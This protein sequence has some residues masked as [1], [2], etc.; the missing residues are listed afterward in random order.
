MD[1]LEVIYENVEKN[2]SQQTYLCPGDNTGIY[3]GRRFSR[4][5][6]L[7]MRTLQLRGLRGRV[8]GGRCKPPLFSRVLLFCYIYYFVIHFVP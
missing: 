6:H 5:H 8:E 3:F 1:F 4:Q 2:I 7:V